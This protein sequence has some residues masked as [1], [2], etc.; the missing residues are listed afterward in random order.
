MNTLS[1]KKIALSNTEKNKEKIQHLFLI[2]EKILEILNSSEKEIKTTLEAKILILSKA[3]SAIPFFHGTEIDQIN[4]FISLWIKSKNIEKRITFENGCSLKTDCTSV[5]LP[6]LKTLD[7]KNPEEVK[8]IKN[9]FGRYL[10][11]FDLICSDEGSFFVEIPFF[12]KNKANHPKS[13]VT[14]EKNFKNLGEFGSGLK[15]NA[16]NELFKKIKLAQIESDKIAMS[17]TK[18]SFDFI[19]GREVQ[20]GLPSLGKRR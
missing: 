19:S 8:S 2:Q 4:S 20:G 1:V 9:K 12:E 15:F 10:G 7:I 17:Y 14:K 16:I 18:T 5:W 6:E 13:T 3:K 11:S